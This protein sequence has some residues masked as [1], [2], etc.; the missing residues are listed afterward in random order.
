MEGEKEKCSMHYEYAKYYCEDCCIYLCDKCEI[1]H[2]S[3]FLKHQLYDLNKESVDEILKGRCQIEYHNKKFQYF[4]KTHNILCCGLCISKIKDDNNGQHS[5]CDV[6]LIEDIQDEKKKNLK[7]NIETLKPLY[8]ELNIYQFERFLEKKE[9]LKLEI[10]EN[11]SKIRKALDY[12]EAKILHDLEKEFNDKCFNQDLIK[13]AINIST[14]LDKGETIAKEWDDDKLLSNLDICINIEEYIKKMNDLK[15]DIEKY[16]IEEIPALCFEDNPTNEILEKINSFGS[17]NIKKYRILMLGLD[18]AGKTALLY[19]IKYKKAVKTIPTISFNTETIDYKGKNFTIWD[20][21]GQDKL[22]CL[23]NHYYPNTDGIIFVVDSKDEE[24]IEE[25]SKEIKKLANE[26]ELKNIPILVLANKQDLKESLAPDKITEK[27]GLR[28]LTGRS[29]LVQGCEA[30][31]GRG[32]IEGL[33]W[34]A[35]CLK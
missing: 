7:K 11:F 29:W 24:R 20:I 30:I 22:R 21:G 3:V 26:E 32:V 35:V 4:C 2:S 18:S 33:D 34:L 28:C 10:K 27:L 5:D 1:Y 15:K 25:A 6:C 19:Q 14:L 31:T 17:I 13:E 9:K 12:R 8:D 23:W 16:N